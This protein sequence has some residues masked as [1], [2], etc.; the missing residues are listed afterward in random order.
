[1]KSLVAA[2]QMTS[3]SDKPENLAHAEYLIE[4]AASLGAKLISLPENFAFFGG[5]DEDALALAEPLDG[6]SIARLKAAAKK[7]RIWLSLGGFQEK[8]TG[9]DKV[10]NSHLLIDAKGELKA[11]YRKIHLFEARLSDGNI[12]NEGQRVKSGAKALC[13]ETPFFKAGLAICF[14]LRFPNLFNGLRDEG[15]QV[16]LIPSAFTKMTGE[17]H[18]E[19]LLR[20]R[21]IENQCYVIA[22][23]QVGRNNHKRE[24]FGHAMIV[25]PWGRVL[26]QCE[27][28]DDLAMA[29]IDLTKLMMVREQINLKR[30]QFSY[31]N[32]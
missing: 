3:T 20:A 14:D 25:D 4:K 19:I 28:T 10:Y 31:E 9:S 8:I 18:W 16:L 13:F 15:A 26:A 2:A 21:A 22:A 7:S 5:A 24:T 6:E 32:L 17:A 12:Y 27:D 23:A 1:M 30:Q 11:V 29:E